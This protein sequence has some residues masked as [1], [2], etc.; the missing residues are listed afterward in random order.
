MVNVIID[1]TLGW[2]NVPHSIGLIHSLAVIISCLLAIHF[3]KAYF[4]KKLTR[5]KVNL[6]PF[7][8]YF[9][10]ILIPRLNIDNK[11]G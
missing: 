6:C 11:S 1:C 3:L 2:N 7:K 4:K 9:I 5:L 8:I 10:T